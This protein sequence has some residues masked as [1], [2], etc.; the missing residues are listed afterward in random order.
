[1][2]IVLLVVSWF[3]PMLVQEGLRASDFFLHVYGQE[4]LQE[5]R[6]DG[7]ARKLAQTRVELWRAVL[8]LPLQV[9][10]VPLLLLTWPARLGLTRW[11]LG[12]NLLL[13]LLAALVLT[14][15]VYG[16]QYGVIMLH[17]TW[18]Q[19]PIEE[20]PLL[21][22]RQDILP[23][24]WVVLILSVMLAAPVLEELLFRGM[25]QPWFASR[26]W[27]AVLPTAFALLLAVVSRSQGLGQYWGVDWGKVLLELAPAFFVLVMAPIVVILQQ[28]C[29]TPVPAGVFGTSLLFAAAH[30]SV[31]PSPVPLLVLGLGLGWLAQRTGSLV[32]PI[33][34]HALFNGVGCVLFWWGVK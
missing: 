23:F 3:C 27:G 30:A 19:Q 9:A 26:P 13:G 32:A 29:R 16:I 31:W 1:M 15:V 21:G 4:L 7:P 20:H 2:V 8:S 34:V 5:A 14:P 12:S 24:E 28:G 6:G 18:L 17:Q 10:T 22:L 11:K 33:L 25:M